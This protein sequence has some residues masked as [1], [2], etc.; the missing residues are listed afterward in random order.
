MKKFGAVVLIAALVLQ[1]F[2]INIF[3][4]GTGDTYYV[5]PT[6]S[7]IATAGT[8]SNPFKTIN[9]ASKYLRPG[10]TCYIMEGV[11]RET[12][13]PYTNGTSDK[14][15]TFAAYEDDNVVISGCDLI[16]DWSRH[17]GNVYKASMDWDIGNGEGNIIYYNNKLGF[18]GRWPNN[19]NNLLDHKTYPVATSA[20]VS[21]IDTG[22]SKVVLSGTG[23][24]VVEAGTKLWCVADPAYYAIT[25][26]LIEPS[27]RTS[28][29]AKIKLTNNPIAGDIYALIGSLSLV[30]VEGEWYKDKAQNTLYLYSN[31]DPNKIEVEAKKREYGID[32]S[33]RK[34]IVFDGV[35]LRAT[36]I[37][38]NDYTTYCTYK[39][40]TIDTVDRNTMEIGY[41]SSKGI[42]V[43]GT[44]NT[45]KGCEIRNCFGG[46]IT[47][48][49]SYHR[50]LNNY[51]HHTNFEANNGRSV[52]I[53]GTNQL[54]SRNTIC[55]TARFA[56]GGTFSDSVISYNDM[57]N[58]EGLTKDGGVLYLNDHDYGMSEIHHNYIHD[59]LDPNGPA[60]MGLYFDTGTCSLLVYNNI[61]YNIDHLTEEQS[62][63]CAATYSDYCIYFNNTIVNHKTK[64]GHYPLSTAVL[65]GGT[66]IN[67]LF[68]TTGHDAGVPEQKDWIYHNNIEDAG[69]SGCFNDEASYDYSLKPGCKAI[70]AGVVIPGVNEDY[71]G[72]APDVGAREFGAEEWTAGHNFDIDYDDEFALNLE[73]PFKNLLKNREFEQGLDYWDTVS[74]T[75]SLMKQSSWGFSFADVIATKNGYYGLML[76]DGDAVNQRLSGLKPNTEYQLYCYSRTAGEFTNYTQYKA[77][78]VSSTMSTNTGSLECQDGNSASVAFTIDFDQGQFNTLKLAISNVKTPLAYCA[79]KLD[80]INGPEI[81]RAYFVRQNGLWNN[82]NFYDIALQ[83]V[84]GVHDV[85]FVFDSGNTGLLK[86]TEM[87]GFELFNKDSADVA[88]FK[89]VTDSGDTKIHERTSPTYAK[90]P[91]KLTFTTGQAGYADITL[92]HMGGD[93]V[94]YFDAL[95][96]QEIYTDNIKPQPVV[97]A[98]V[99]LTDLQGN[100]Y[101]NVSD[102]ALGIVNLMFENHTSDDF[103]VT[104]KVTSYTATGRKCDVVTIDSPISANNTEKLGLGITIA[105]SKGYL[106]LEFASEDGKVFEYTIPVWRLSNGMNADVMLKG[107]VI[108]DASDNVQTSLVKNQKN[109]LTVSLMNTD[110]S[111]VTCT[112]YVALYSNENGTPRLIGITN[113][114]EEIATG[115]DTVQIDI[116]VPNTAGEITATLLLWR[117]DG[118][119]QPITEVYK[120]R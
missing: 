72:D 21:Q 62:V 96:V 38:T 50:V 12:V 74:G 117:N 20:S 75:P 71:V 56:T 7:D 32:L 25:G 120:F 81:G 26:T 16:T 67:N 87:N 90:L 92:T 88:Q 61:I 65:N 59:N 30:D 111:P 23:I 51:I 53:Y 108:K 82:I 86:N 46:A 37:K 93:N 60:Q 4:E 10:D 84:T 68:K 1:L 15:I 100:V 101:D 98:N 29:T 57:Y 104:G 107:L 105:D 33:N 66:Y 63:L 27:T 64:M 8:I 36:S 83:K 70:D 114:S 80:S 76:K 55:N 40:A 22:T 9:Y 106:V 85:Y 112:G 17:E 48:N 41:P 54:V 14:P 47:L 110:D 52:W 113:V 39:N 69:A 24:P 2:S 18:E 44:Y 97:L 79:L 31:V 118:S 94:I 34:N 95:G 43:N 42:I 73:L 89:I 49:G 91:D 6:G 13:T 99:D 58:T 109:K 5:S 28:I 77:G 119:L 115:S 3:A 102:G 11:Y 19:Q 35:G 116:D 78:T 103:T 45:I